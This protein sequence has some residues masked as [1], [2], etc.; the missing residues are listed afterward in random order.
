M[1]IK[2]RSPTRIIEGEESHK[3]E[4]AYVKFPG[5]KIIP[6]TLSS[7]ETSTPYGGT[8]LEVKNDMEKIKYLWQNH[9]KARYTH[10]HTHPY[11]PNNPEFGS[12]KITHS[13]LPSSK[14]MGRFL[15]DDSIKSMVIAQINRDT[16]VIEGYFCLRKTKN[17]EPMGYYAIDKDVTL[18]EVS[19]YGVFSRIPKLFGIGVRQRKIIKSLKRYEKNN[20]NVQIADKPEQLFPL[21]KGL[22]EKYSL[23]YR[24]VPA[25]GYEPDEFNIG[26]VRKRTGLEQK[27]SAIIAVSGF[28]ASLFFMASNFTGNVIGNLNSNSTSV[29]GIILFLV[30][31]IGT[32]F[33][34]H[35]KKK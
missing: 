13:P 35:R 6:V 16:N 26:F 17:T 18:S 5:E 24:F 25:E 22:V 27:L 21:V 15:G 1:R 7:Q 11:S 20:I 14:D 28:T 29:I 4:H 10:I 33:Y 34:F 19:K 23:H 2:K 12:R 31:L 30:G 3:Y 9:N 32:F 8:R